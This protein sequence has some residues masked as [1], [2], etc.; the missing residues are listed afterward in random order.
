MA[1]ENILTSMSNPLPGEL[2]PSASRITKS[3]P[4]SSP[5]SSVSGISLLHIVIPCVVISSDPKG[6]EDTSNALS[7]FFL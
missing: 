2:S 7:P 3:I 5:Y 1:I 4:K 6:L